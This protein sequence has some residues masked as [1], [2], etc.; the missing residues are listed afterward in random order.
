VIE[1][2]HAGY[3]LAQELKQ[4]AETVLDFLRRHPL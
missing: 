3:V 4:C 1:G 2:A